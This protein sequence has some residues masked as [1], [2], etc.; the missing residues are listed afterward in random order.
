MP[1]DK[2]IVFFDSECAGCS[3]LVRFLY[4]I[5]SAGTLSFAPLMGKTYRELFNEPPNLST[6]VLWDRTRR[7]EKSDAVF[8]MV[9]YLGLPWKPLTGLLWVPRVLRDWC[10]DQVASRRHW[11]GKPKQCALLS[12][13]QARR[14][15]P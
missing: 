5:D 14:V 4:K 2:P 10:Y 12:T 9:G 3:A 15:L 6:L 1:H 13:E 8:K 11:I 7:F